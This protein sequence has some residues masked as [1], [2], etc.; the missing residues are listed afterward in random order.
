[1]KCNQTFYKPA[2]PHTGKKGQPRKDGVKLKLDDS[3]TLIHPDE[4]WEGTDAKGHPVQVR[5]WKKMHVK[6]ARWLDLTIIQVIR[7]QAPDSERD[8]R[9]SWFVYR[10]QDPQE[11]M[12]QVALLYCLRFGQEHG[13]R[14]DKQALLWTEPRLRTPEQ[15]DLWSQI[16]AIVHNHV[17]VARDLVEAE[18]VGKQ[19]TYAHPATS[20][21]RAGQIIAPLR[22]PCLPPQTSWKTERSRHRC[23]CS[24]GQALSCCSQNG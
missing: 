23:S 14:F 17:V 4:T 11:G 21:T 13:Y 22:D 20:A 16:V 15:F 1:L 3:S 2:P 5:W 6:D 9:I 10:G 18:P 8:P 19:A 7:P 12:A 24:Q